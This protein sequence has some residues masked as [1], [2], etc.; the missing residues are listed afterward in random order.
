MSYR[1]PVCSCTCS[2]M[3]DT[4][5]TAIT[6][7][8]IVKGARYERGDD[9][10]RPMGAGDRQFGY[11]R[12]VRLQLLQAADGAR[13]A[14]IQRLQRFPGG[15]VRGDVRL[16]AHHLCPLGLAAEPVSRR[17]LAIP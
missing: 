3:A 10:V 7:G 13:L 15:A 17:R 5:A 11:L 12:S 16:S 14:L 2:C 9:G 1:S 4:A 6:A 8:T